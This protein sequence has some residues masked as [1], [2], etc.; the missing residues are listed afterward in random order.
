VTAVFV[1][2]LVSDFSEAFLHPF[3]LKEMVNPSFLKPPGL[4][5]GKSL[6]VE[7]GPA[8]HWF[9]FLRFTYGNGKANLKFLFNKRK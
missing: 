5:I 3:F 6:L 7:L 4:K 2:S 8:F 9:L 1:G